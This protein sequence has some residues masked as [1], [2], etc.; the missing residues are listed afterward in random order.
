M[1]RP[2]KPIRYRVAVYV[3]GGSAPI[4]LFKGYTSL[5]AAET[6]AE[7]IRS[8]AARNGW[9]HVVQVEQEI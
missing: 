5:L 9:A 4:R 8:Q 2:R 3:S 6:R 7:Q 1:A